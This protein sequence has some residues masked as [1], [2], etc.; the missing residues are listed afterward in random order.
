MYFKPGTIRE[1]AAKLLQGGAFKS[2]QARQFLEF[3][4]AGKRGIARARRV[5]A[6]GPEGED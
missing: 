4:T 6:A 2:R 5:A 3:M 1:A